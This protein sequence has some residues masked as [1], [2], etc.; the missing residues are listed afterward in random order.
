MALEAPDLREHGEFMPLA[1]GTPA[2]RS[3]TLNS[4]FL[5]EIKDDN[6]Q[7]RSLLATLRD[8]TR[9]PLVARNHREQVVE[10]I[11]ELRDQLALHFTLEEAYGYFE[12][13]V[14]ASPRIAERAAELRSQHLALFTAIQRIAESA[15]VWEIRFRH[16]HAGC[17][18]AERR[19]LPATQ[20]FQRIVEQFQRFIDQLLRH[21]RE[22]N[23]LILDALTTDIGGE[24]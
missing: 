18:I 23:A 10:M 3:L 24:G 22:E 17:Q 19:M 11:Q 13:A 2:T 9:L 15:R 14:D 4:A 8:L 1:P 16:I 7:L 5:Q 12:D 20:T 6:R 21:E